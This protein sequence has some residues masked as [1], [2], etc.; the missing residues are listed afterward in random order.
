[1]VMDILFLWR[2]KEYGKLQD[3]IELV[4]NSLCLSAGSRAVN[5]SSGLRQI[6]CLV[7]RSSR[8]ME[9][10]RFTIKYCLVSELTYTKLLTKFEKL[11][12]SLS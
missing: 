7:S 12:T 6:F 10:E 8:K 5:I 4:N 1:M 2:K 3:I 11:N 9:F